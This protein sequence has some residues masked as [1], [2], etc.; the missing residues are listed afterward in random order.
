[1]KKYMTTLT[2]LVSLTSLSILHAEETMGDMEM[3]SDKF[4][5]QMKK[6]ENMAMKMEKEN[7]GRTK[8][9]YMSSHMRNMKDMMKMMGNMNNIMVKD[10]K[11]NMPMSS[12]PGG[13]GKGMVMGDKSMMGK[14]PRQDS[15]MMGGMMQMMG[16][17]MGRDEVMQQRMGMMHSMMEQMLKHMEQLEKQ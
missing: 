14:G 5:M 16:G 11:Q 7:S 1:M 9:Q 12:C 4:N 17:M 8:R 10:K 15:M 3:M 13:N 6:T 2:L